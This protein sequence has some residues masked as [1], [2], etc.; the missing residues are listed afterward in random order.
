V[1]QSQ[2]PPEYSEVAPATNFSDTASI[3][4]SGSAKKRRWF[5]SAK[6]REDGGGSSKASVDLD[7]TG[8]MDGGREYEGDRRQEEMDEHLSFTHPQERD[9]EWG[10]GDDAGMGLS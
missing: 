9:G 4:T 1:D 10:L 5:R 7:G 3:S 6:G 8:S 2:P